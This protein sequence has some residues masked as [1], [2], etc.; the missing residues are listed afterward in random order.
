MACAQIVGRL[1]PSIKPCL[2]KPFCGMY[3]GPSVA[4][5]LVWFDRS[6]IVGAVN[7]CAP[8]GH[9]GISS[10]AMNGMHTGH[11][12]AGQSGL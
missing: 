12:I 9:G 6:I 3:A 11:H 10:S 1:T 5:A 7:G 8:P 4:R 2:C